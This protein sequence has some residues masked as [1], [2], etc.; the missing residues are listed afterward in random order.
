MLRHGL[1]RLG[2]QCCVAVLVGGLGLS[3]ASAQSY[4]KSAGKQY[5]VGVV[6]GDLPNPFYNSVYKGLLQEAKNLG[7]VSVLPMQGG[8]SFAPSTQLPFLDGMLSK[9]VSGLI[10]APVS[11]T[12]LTP[13]LQ[14]FVRRGIPVIT[15]DTTITDTKILSGA[16]TSNDRQGGAAMADYLGAR[17]R[18]HGT[19]AVFDIAPGTGSTNPRA[20]G[21][22]AEMAKRFPKIKLLPTQYTG[23]SVSEADSTAA[24]LLL[25]HPDITGFFG[26]EFFATEGIATAL[27]AAGKTKTI[28]LVGYDATPPEVKLLE[29]DKVQAL[30]VQPAV[31]EGIQ[32]MKDLYDHLMGK[33]FKKS[34]EIANI[35]ATRKNMNQPEVR[36]AF[37][38]AS[39][40]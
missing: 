4:V 7:N 23:I 6:V 21:F 15:V 32:A 38:L 26:V 16:V 29:Q 2:I 28:A 5:R 12:A 36:N 10:T 30:V 20:E 34:V 1:K 37:Y 3:A 35:I 31:A 22:R 40:P 8:A 18:G 19:V 17:L 9:Q 13:T 24:S 33:Q 11:T 27:A 14:R 39:V 25:A